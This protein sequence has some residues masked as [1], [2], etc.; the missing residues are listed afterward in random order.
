MGE[1]M[2]A[3]LYGFFDD[4]AV[5]P[6]G[7]AP[8]DAAV[9]DHLARRS[10]PLAALTGPLLLSL[11]QVAEAHRLAQETAHLLGIDLAAAPLRIGVVIPAGRLHDALELAAR[12]M[13]GIRVTGLELKTSS[14]S[15]QADVAALQQADTSASRHI[16]FTAAQ[17][18]E[19]ALTALQGGNVDLKFRTGGLDARLFPAPGELAKVIG[20]SVR[21]RVP[22]KLTAGLHQAVRHTNPAT[23]FIH[24]GFLNIAVATG[25]ADQGAGTDRLHE[26]LEEE[27]GTRLATEVRVF[28][29]NSWRR[30]FRSFG[31]CSIDEPLESLTA[32][33]L[34][35]AAFNRF[36]N[37]FRAD[38]ITLNTPEHERAH[39]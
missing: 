35:P 21:Q 30:W 27:D 16:E 26:I 28:T 17:I 32:L 23:G 39:P 5:F 11:D 22:F 20:Q 8:L 9:R 6:P 36:G 33:G 25:A 24:H 2:T 10:S 38:A 12:T 19:G 37:G 18:S 13:N 15:W 4:A 31:T 3:G 7:S 34:D 14:D 29:T 1:P